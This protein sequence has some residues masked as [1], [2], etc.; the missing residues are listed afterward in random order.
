MN[1]NVGRVGKFECASLVLLASLISALFAINTEKTYQN[2]NSIYAA[3]LLAAFVTLAIFLLTLAAMRRIGARDLNELFSLSLGRVAGAAL[4]FVLSMALLIAAA[5]PLI[6]ILIILCRYV[7]VEAEIADVMLYFVPCLVLPLFFGF[8]TIARSAKLFL[9]VTVLSFVIAYVIAAPSYDVSRLYPLIGD[10]VS[11]ML[12]K[13]LTATERFFPALISLLILARSAQGLDSTASTGSLGTI[14]GGTLASGALLCLGMT[15]PYKE[16]S[17]MHAPMYRVTMS[18]RTGSS[19][20]RTDKVLLFFW[21]IA[22]FLSSLFYTFAA[23]SAFC[24][25]FR[26]RDVRPAAAAF[27]M[28]VSAMVLIGHEDFVWFER[29]AAF[30]SDWLWAFFAGPVI[31]AAIAAFLHGKKGKKA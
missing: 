28:T 18:V 2:G 8:E 31:L 25:A 4:S 5:L 12:Q 19:Y 24:R 9:A 29:A 21:M 27:G 20:L 13:A 16:L 26:I 30:F 23:A 10:G 6:R 11:G 22:G 3:T 1:S 7:Y 15:Y 17:K 14:A